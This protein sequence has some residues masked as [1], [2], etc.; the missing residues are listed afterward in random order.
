MWISL[1]GEMGGS[2]PEISDV[3]ASRMKL[4]LGKEDSM[5]EWFKVYGCYP[6]GQCPRRFESYYCRIFFVLKLCCEL[7]KISAEQVYVL[8]VQ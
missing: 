3:E 6:Y 1:D 4:Q 2:F 7:C 5:T 8:S